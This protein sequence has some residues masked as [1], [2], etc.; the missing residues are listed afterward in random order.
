[1]THTVRNGIA[2]KSRDGMLN[3][4]VGACEEPAVGG[5]ISG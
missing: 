3:S 5:P 2:L 1:M 4:H